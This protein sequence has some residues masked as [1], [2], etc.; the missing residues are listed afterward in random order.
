MLRLKTNDPSGLLAAIKKRID[1]R[2][3]QSWFYDNDGD[4]TLKAPRWEFEAW[5]RPAV[6]I[7]SLN[8]AIVAPLNERLSAE[9]YAVFHAQFMQMV[10]TWFDDQVDEAI[11]TAMPEDADDV[12]AADDDS[13]VADIG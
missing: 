5:L 2:D 4:F 6:E 13:R 10:L 12:G 8:M 7:G 3:I 1:S 11:A 9:T